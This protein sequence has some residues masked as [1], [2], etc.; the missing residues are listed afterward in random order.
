MSAPL[1]R[2]QTEALA[3]V[4]GGAG[5]QHPQRDV[6]APLA[7]VKTR[8]DLAKRPITAHRDHG[9]VRASVEC[10]AYGA[11]GLA[12]GQRGKEIGREPRVL[13]QCERAIDAL[14]ILSALRGRVADEEMSGHR[15]RV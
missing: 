8:R 3:L 13:Q 9:A 4:V 12:S 5:G 15:A 1:V 10:C 11:D 7:R 2:L 14:L 6:L